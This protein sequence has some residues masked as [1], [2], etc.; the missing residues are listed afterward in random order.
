MMTKRAKPNSS[1]LGPTTYLGSPIRCDACD[2]WIPEGAILGKD[3]HT[4]I[5]ISEDGIGEIPVHAKCC[6]SN[7]C[8]EPNQEV[9]R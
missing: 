4:T 2:D 5:M 8:V 7:R 9:G 3:F 6:V 1:E